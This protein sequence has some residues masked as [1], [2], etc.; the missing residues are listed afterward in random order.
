MDIFLESGQEGVK[1]L[2]QAFWFS[3]SVCYP[4][5]SINLPGAEIMPWSLASTEITFISVSLSLVL[6]LAIFR[7]L[8][9]SLYPILPPSVYLKSSCPK[10]F[11]GD[12]G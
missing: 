7:L 6:T 8:S 2:V 10:F 12:P 4:P 9:P 11:C 1:N 5:E 3:P